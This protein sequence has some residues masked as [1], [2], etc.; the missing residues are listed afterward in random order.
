MKFPT[1]YSEFNFDV[2]SSDRIS[3]LKK[4]INDR[5]ILHFRGNI[6]LYHKERELL[7]SLLVKDYAVES[8][9]TFEIKE[10]G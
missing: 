6:S 2:K 3:T 4:R 10:E 9:D 5:D 8:G 7:G 1:Y